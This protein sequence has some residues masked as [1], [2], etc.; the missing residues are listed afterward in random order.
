MIRGLVDGL[1]LGRWPWCVRQLLRGSLFDRADLATKQ[2]IVRILS[3]QEQKLRVT[4]HGLKLLSKL[5][6]GD[7]RKRGQYAWANH[8]DR[9]KRTKLAFEEIVS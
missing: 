3:D 4:R 1:D 7:Y 6:V 8:L 5:R 2:T 9:A